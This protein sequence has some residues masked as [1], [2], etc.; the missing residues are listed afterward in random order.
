MD[1]PVSHN[2]GFDLV[3]VT[4]T[5]A[6]VAGRWLGVGDRESAH[7]AATQAM[8]TAIN[9]VNID[10]CVVIGEEGRIR[11]H[12]P[13]DTGNKVG[14]G[15]GPKVDV[16]LDPID[17][18]RSVVRG[19]PEGAISVAGIAPRGSMW[20]PK[21]AVY[22]EKIVV[23]REAAAALVPECM[24]AP[25]AWTLALIARVK[26]KE[27]R[28]LQVVVL[29]RRRHRDLID[30]IRHAGARVLLRPDGDT[31]GAL[32]A[33]SPDTGADVLMG[34]GGV[35]E[36]VTA[37][38]AVKAMGGAMLGRLAP[39]SQ[40]EM[41]AVKAAGLDTR[42]ILSCDQLVAG[43]QI[44]FAATGVTHSVLLDGVQYRG[45]QAKTHSLVMRSQ[46]GTRRVIRTEYSSLDM[47]LGVRSDF[48]D[49]S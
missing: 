5:T 2:L 35:P 44:F 1:G 41:A 14:T 12:S 13:L 27:V 19:R 20:S 38:C 39:Q 42:Q 46:T 31:T 9:S 45:N 37:A 28:D 15:L 26:G 6:L 25:V 7:L 4:E 3:R 23:D 10:G 8:A 36:G 22:M 21:P 18:T 40:E 17:G 11:E 32:I 33:A 24:D 47:V 16:V 29:D 48:E 34:I 43:D 30:E 49:G